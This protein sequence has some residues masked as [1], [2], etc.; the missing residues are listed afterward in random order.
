MEAARPKL[1]GGLTSPSDY[2]DKH[3]SG[4]NVES[5]AWRLRLDLLVLKREVSAA[6]LKSCV[7]QPRDMHQCMAIA[8]LLTDREV[9]ALVNVWNAHC[10]AMFP[11]PAFGG[12]P[13]KAPELEIPAAPEETQN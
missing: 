12:E 9:A 6:L 8:R 7:L 10:A 2:A 1:L 4:S 13:I 11:G 5:L 3:L